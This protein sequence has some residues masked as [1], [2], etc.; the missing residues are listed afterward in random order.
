[1]HNIFLYIDPSSGSYLIQMLIAGVL[2]SLFFFKNAWLKVKNFFTRK[3][4]G[5]KDEL[6]NEL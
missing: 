1:M 6:D 2:G 3:K 5:I 4:E